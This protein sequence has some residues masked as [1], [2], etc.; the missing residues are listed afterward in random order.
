MGKAGNT[1]H[2]LVMLLVLSNLMTSLNAISI[3]GTRKLLDESRDTVTHWN[4]HE[5]EMM[6]EPVAAEDLYEGRKDSELADYPGSGANDD[7]T[8]TTPTG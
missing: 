2:L 1:L 4:N 6:K 3:S 8:P 7:H 5:M